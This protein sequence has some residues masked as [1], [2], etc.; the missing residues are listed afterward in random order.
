M[1]RRVNTKF[2]TILTI[3][4][5]S[6]AVLALV[7]NKFLFRESPEK[8]INAGKEYIA[9][10]NYEEAVKAFNRAVN[11]DPRNPAVLV[12]YGD[13]VN[14]LSASDPTMAYQARAAW[15]QAVAVDPTNKAALDRLMQH[16]SDLA[17][18]SGRADT[19][20][21]LKDTADKLFAADPKNSAAEIAG[22]TAIIR[23]WLMGIEKDEKLITD[24]IAKLQELMVRYPDNADLPMFAAE[25]KVRLAERERQRE[26]TADAAKLV[27]EADQIMQDAVK[28]SPTAAMYFSAAQVVQMQ[29]KLASAPLGLGQKSLNVSPQ[30]WHKRL[31]EYYAKAREL[32]KP[33]DP[34][35]VFIN[36]ADARALAD[37]PDEANK[38]LG[39]L[40]VK[41]PN[42]LQ[43]RLA[44]AEQLSSDRH[45][46]LAP[47]P[48][49]SA[50]VQAAATK[51]QQAAIEKSRQDA[52]DILDRPFVANE[53]IG[54]RAFLTREWQV[55][56]LVMA[57]NL[58]LEQYAVAKRNG[59]KAQIDKLLP[60]INDGLAMIESKDGV[61]SPRHAAFARQAVQAKRRQ[62]QGD[63]DA[64]KSAVRWR[65]RTRR[66]NR[67]ATS[68]SDGKSSICWLVP[69]SRC[70]RSAGQGSC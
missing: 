39:D 62:Y 46:E 13:A 33:D 5:V 3:I 35:Y 56:T 22:Q 9:Q 68:S 69:M 49:S 1:A 27:D 20:N 14:Q 45:K 59:D 55:R 29:E 10:K 37:K 41:Q 53:V 65:K 61:D 38:I 67:R 51:A 57:T 63:S 60:R 64:G 15:N 30:E 26:Q 6:L 8:Y 34:L 19:F 25:G 54:P 17:N 32:A 12:E 43:V 24:T 2:L 47:D 66:T 44:M 23:P 48:K 16:W 28:R 42:D 18:I 50:D 58:R 21:N 52:I 36:L 31:L 40:L 7:G 4:I 70:S 11:L